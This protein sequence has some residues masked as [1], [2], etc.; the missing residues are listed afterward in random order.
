MTPCHGVRFIL[1]LHNASG[2]LHGAPSLCPGLMRTPW[3]HRRAGSYRIRE[4]CLGRDAAVA[5]L[6]AISVFAGHY[7]SCGQR[8]IPSDD[9]GT[10][11]NS[12]CALRSARSVVKEGLSKNKFKRQC[13]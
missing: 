10:D 1:E 6:L 12:V 4:H 11:G 3:V 2:I 9:D 8:F 7:R 13:C 5:G